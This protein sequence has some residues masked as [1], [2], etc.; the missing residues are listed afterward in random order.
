M[1]WKEVERC[2]SSPWANIVK[3]AW[4]RVYFV[5]RHARVE[6]CCHPWNRPSNVLH[7]DSEIG[8]KIKDEQD[9]KRKERSILQSKLTKLAIRIG[10]VGKPPI[11]SLLVIRTN[12]Q[13]HSPLGLIV[14]ILTVIVLIVRFSWEEFVVRQQPWRAKYWNR[15]IRFFITGITVLVVA[16]P[17]GL[18]L[19]V[20]VSL[21]YAVK[22]NHPVCLHPAI[23]FRLLANDVRQ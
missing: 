6:Y 4:S 10:Y 16:V 12:D 11:S 2:W 8:A 7:L 18:P 13:T 3:S 19:A 1:W 15:F 17:E 5:R 21:A 14:A 20:T 22:V 23:V 9:T